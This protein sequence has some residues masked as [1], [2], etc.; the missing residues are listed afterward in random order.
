M[1][2]R[3]FTIVLATA[4]LISGGCATGFRVGGDRYGAGVGGY[5][6]AVPAAVSAREAY[7]LPPCP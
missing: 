1:R 3:I 6:G 4:S 2:T 5:V 7:L